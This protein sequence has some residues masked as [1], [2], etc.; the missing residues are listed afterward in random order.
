[1]NIESLQQ[2]ERILFALRGLYDKYGYV[3]YKMNKFEEYDLYARN[4]DFLIS[5]GVITFTD[6]NGKLMALKPDVT[7]SIVK[8]TKDDDSRV[9]K[10]YYNENVY[11][12]SG[13]THSFK[14]IMQVGLEAMGDIDDYCIF[15]V[16]SLSAESL[17]CTERNCILEFSH[18][19][20]LSEILRYVGIPEE[21]SVMRCIGE[22]NAHELTGIC[23]SLGISEEKCALLKNILS[24]Y[25]R[26]DEVLPEVRKLLTGIVSEGTLSSFVGIARALSNSARGEMY[27]LDFS[28]VSD[29]RYYNGFVFR[30]FAEGIPSSVLSGGQ[31]DTMMAKMKRKSGAIGFAVYLDMLEQYEKNE[32][33]V[34]NLLVYEDCTVSQI[35]AQTDALIEKGESVLVQKSI[36]SDVKYKKLIRLQGGKRI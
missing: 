11:R 31:Y 3:R 35:K 6:T 25:G 12:V 1:M 34:D 26:V 28:I 29:I 27:Y 2:S 16:M 30:G 19:G 36:P 17:A 8:N 4:K 32:Y 20:V 5:E 33:D 21:Q 7:L 24:V 15:E 18:L 22:K 10:L 13:G 9:Q 23:A 14:E